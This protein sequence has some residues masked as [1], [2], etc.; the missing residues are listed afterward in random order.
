MA[1]LVL[2][3]SQDI[4]TAFQAFNTGYQ[5]IL[6]NK[7]PSAL[8]FQ[9]LITNTPSGKA[10]GVAFMW[11]S[12]DQEAG[13][14]WLGQIEALGKVVLN[15][16]TPTT[17][18]KYLELMA[19]VV[20]TSIYGTVKTTSVRSITSEIIQIIGRNAEKMPTR[21]GAQLVIHELRGPSAV[22]KTDSVFGSRES[23]FVLEL[24]AQVTEEESVKECEE[25][26][27]TFQ[28]ELRGSDPRNILPSSYISLTAPE[29]MD[30]RRIYG[31]NYDTLIE[32]KR[33][34]DP[35]NVFNLA[36]PRI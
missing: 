28:N 10:F 1:G 9:Q 20:P 29:E 16:V 4:S 27:A 13:R 17:I 12:D 30:L 7:P 24:I 2:F 15:S 5:K 33:E 22:P 23:H 31:E 36:V 21:F 32:L 35:H 25:W 18:S 3:D 34:F 26:V 11:S 19:P 6:A 14:A 8:G